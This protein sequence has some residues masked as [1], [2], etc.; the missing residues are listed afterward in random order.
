M[1]WGSR[2]VWE[3]ENLPSVEATESLS[4]DHETASW[5]VNWVIQ[6]GILFISAETKILITYRWIAFS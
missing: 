5:V 3:T 4:L 1:Q 6:K 2:E